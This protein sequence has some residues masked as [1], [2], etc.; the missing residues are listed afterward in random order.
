VS[1]CLVD[2]LPLSDATV[3]GFGV[4]GGS[5]ECRDDQQAVNVGWSDYYGAELADQWID[6]TGDPNGNYIVEITVDPDNV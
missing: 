2:S 3:T 5:Q 6:I 4:F 1:F